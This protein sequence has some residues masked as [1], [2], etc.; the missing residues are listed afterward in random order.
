MQKI[1]LLI[2]SPVALQKQY[3][4]VKL[5]VLYLLSSS[6]EYLA[7]NIQKLGLVDPN[8]LFDKGYT[9]STVDGEDVNRRK[10][11]LKGKELTTITNEYRIISKIKEINKRK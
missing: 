9:I 1:L 7:F 5:N 10:E 3:E 2:W 4:L 8:Q 6:K 11:A